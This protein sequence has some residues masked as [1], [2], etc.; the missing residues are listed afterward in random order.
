MNLFLLRKLAFKSV[1]TNVTRQ[2]FP[3]IKTMEHL[4]YSYEAKILF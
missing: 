3:L 2:K 4:K 1:Q